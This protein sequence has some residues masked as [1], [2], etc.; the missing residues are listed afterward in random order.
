MNEKDNFI[1]K[2]GSTIVEHCKM[3]S[4]STGEDEDFC[5]LQEKQG[6]GNSVKS[7]NAKRIAE[8]TYS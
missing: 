2:I 8:S 7:Y 4:R 1:N 6:F 3:K 5:F